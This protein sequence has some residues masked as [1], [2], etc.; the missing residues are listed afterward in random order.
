M[1]NGPS[2]QLLHIPHSGKWRESPHPGGRPCI[3]PLPR[4]AVVATGF[5]EKRSLDSVYAHQLRRLG[6]ATRAWAPLGASTSSGLRNGLYVQFRTTEAK[7]LTLGTK[8][9]SSEAFCQQLALC[10]L[11]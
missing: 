11:R 2:S 4:E 1:L 8:R 3:P 7:A 6:L 9:S 5:L 10:G